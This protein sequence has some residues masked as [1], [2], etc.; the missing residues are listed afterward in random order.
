MPVMC[1]ACSFTSK[2]DSTHGSHGQG[3]PFSFFK[4]NTL[5]TLCRDKKRTLQTIKNLSYVSK[6]FSYSCIF[7]FLFVASL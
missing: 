6:S 2:Q 3:T 4:K 5:L 7:E 1:G